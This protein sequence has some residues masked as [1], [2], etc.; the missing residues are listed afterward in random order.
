V[1]LLTTVALSIDVFADDGGYWDGVV[2]NLWRPST[3]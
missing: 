3:C 1:I 2:G